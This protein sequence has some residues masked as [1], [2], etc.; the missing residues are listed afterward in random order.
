MVTDVTARKF[1]MLPDFDVS[2]LRLQ[3]PIR[4]HVF[5]KTSNISMYI[6]IFALLYSAHSMDSM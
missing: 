4:I 5:D 1:F 6:S 2:M 3:V